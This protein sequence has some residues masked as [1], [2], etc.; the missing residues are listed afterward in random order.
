MLIQKIEDLFEAYRMFDD[1]ATR[2]AIYHKIDSLSYEARRHWDTALAA[3][4]PKRGLT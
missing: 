2:A 1:S 3:S 4:S